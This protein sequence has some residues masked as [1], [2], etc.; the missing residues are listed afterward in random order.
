MKGTFEEAVLSDLDVRDI[1]Y[2]YEPS[3]LPY[4]VERHYIPD[5]AVGDMIVELKGY[6]RQDSQR[7]MKAIK[8]LHNHY[9]QLLDEGTEA[10]DVIC[11]E[12]ELN[13]VTPE[14]VSEV[15]A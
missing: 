5:L 6:F 2:E 1:S 7:K 9:Q 8:A 10:E 4:F 15:A 12:G 14:E 13:Y 3:K 11:F